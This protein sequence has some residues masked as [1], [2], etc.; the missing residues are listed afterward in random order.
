MSGSKNSTWETLAAV[1]AS[2]A[3]ST[4]TPLGFGVDLEIMLVY[5]IEKPYRLRTE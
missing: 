3:S 2:V 4:A 1:F 5:P